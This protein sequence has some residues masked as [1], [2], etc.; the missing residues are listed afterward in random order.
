M[1]IA[2]IAILAALLLLALQGAQAQARTAACM[3]QIRQA[4]IWIVSYSE[5]YDGR[6]PFNNVNGNAESHYLRSWSTGT[7]CGWGNLFF[8]G[9]FTRPE[10]LSCPGKRQH[11]MGP[12]RG[13]IYETDYV[14]GWWAG[15]W[16][17]MMNV[18]NGDTAYAVKFEQYG[19]K[20][21]RGAWIGPSGSYVSYTG[22]RLMVA[23]VR[24]HNAWAAPPGFNWWNSSQP[25]DVPHMG[26]GNMVL[27]DG[28]A[29]SRPNMF[30]PTARISQI[31]SERALLDPWNGDGR[32][33]RNSLPH[34]QY[35][36]DWW[37]WAEGLV[38]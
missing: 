26:K 15:Q 29:Q 9:Y 10:F 5:D 2:I 23:D 20:C 21:S 18:A 37:T 17:S 30:G 3:G 31:S 1:V 11:Y 25:L 34:H 38:R 14:V 19:S 12:D 28:S 32:G 36:R 7:N 6:L 24:S 4:Y 33:D 22:L 8:N 27:F 16:D 35:G 13:T